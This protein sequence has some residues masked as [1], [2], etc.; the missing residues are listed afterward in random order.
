MKYYL[1]SGMNESNDYNFYDDIACKFKEELKDFE[2]IVYIPTYPENKEKCNNLAKSEKF[3]NIGINFKRSIVLDNS[4]NKEEVKETIEQNELIFLYGG[5]PFKQIEFINK[6]NIKELIKN[7]VIIGLSAGS[8]NMCKNSICT[9]DEDF[10][11]SKMYDGMGLVEFSIEPHF[12]INNIEVLDDLKKYSKLT[13][14]YALEDDAYIIVDNNDVKYFG[15]VYL[16][17]DGKIKLQE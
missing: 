12:N 16:I 13:N 3:K 5:D 15:N 6:Y 11:E 4:Y 7:K 9:K 10:N 2:T 17:K 1:L 14:I 8:I